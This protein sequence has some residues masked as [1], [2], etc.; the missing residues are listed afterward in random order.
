MKRIA[1]LAL[2]VAC[3]AC[4]AVRARAEDA[5]ARDII[6]RAEFGI[7]NDGHGYARPS[8]RYYF[9]LST[10]RLFAETIYEHR[11]NARLEGSIDFWLRGGLLVPLGS[12][13]EAEFSLNHLCRHALSLSGPFVLSVNEALGRLWWRSGGAELGLG[14]G[15]YFNT[16][17]VIFDE[18]G[19]GHGLAVANFNW[20]RI[21][22]TP[23]SLTS[24]LKAA[25][26]KKLMPDIEVRAAVAPGISLFV[27]NVTTYQLPNMTDFGLGFGSNQIEQSNI[28]FVSTTAEFLPSDEDHK[29]IVDQVADIDLFRTAD[30]RVLI[31]A[32]AYLP[33]LRGKSFAG[34]FRPEK[35]AY[36]FWL[37]YEHRLG[38]STFL[39]G[40]GYYRVDIPVD[41]AQK[42][43]T[44]LGLGAG[45]R[46][47]RVFEALDSPVR[48][49]VSAGLDS[50]H[51]YDLSLSVGL[52][53]VHGQPDFGLEAKARL[54][55]DAEVAT[56]L[57][58]TEF[59][60]RTRVRLM[61]GVDWL[62]DLVPVVND[63]RRVWV[64][65]GFFREIRSGA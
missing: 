2:I 61:A 15:A 60:T 12:G 42:F 10:V 41:R 45:L 9:P 13:V 35:I 5:D 20:E 11:L 16:S 52:N 58:L 31:Q 48:Y 1:T 32:E 3:L 54:N 38:A 4:A 8:L 28:S 36:P 56:V 29:L 50:P 65:F 26:F 22:G 6:L 17:S 25:D 21:A 33:I 57:V 34:L 55:A 47:Q 46:N 59:G 18:P 49:E 53:T 37:E 7:S 51:D 19:T 44:V 30:D 43:S 39:F 63:Q 40:Y 23:F 27:R 14:L 64:G 24:E 62:R